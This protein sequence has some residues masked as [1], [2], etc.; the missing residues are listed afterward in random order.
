MAAYTAH[1]QVRGK[2]L[3]ATPLRIHSF[4]KRSVFRTTLEQIEAFHKS[5]S[6]LKKLTPPPIFIQVHADHRVSLT[7]GDLEFTLWFGPL[8]IRWLARHEALPGHGFAEWQV[9]GPMAH[10]RHEHE[11]EVVTGGV[12]LF[13]R[14]TLAHKPGFRGL[15]TRLIFDGIPLRILFLYRHWRTKQAVE[16]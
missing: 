10:W 15:L 9:F 8:P 3:L 2:T 4:Q 11:F 5:P 13:D 16:N 14:V 12:A 7:Q 1:I 6:A